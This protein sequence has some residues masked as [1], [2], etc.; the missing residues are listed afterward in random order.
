M[1]KAFFIILFVQSV[2]QGQSRLSADS[3]KA[4]LAVT[5]TDS[6]TLHRYLLF[7]DKLQSDNKESQLLISLWVTEK[8]KQQGFPALS[9]LGH[10]ASARIY[11]E[12]GDYTNA[13]SH[14]GQARLIAHEQGLSIIE[15]K[16]IGLIANIYKSN[17][18]YGKA[19]EYHG[20]AAALSKASNYPT[21][22]GL[23]LYNMGT[24]EYALNPPGKKN[25]EKIIGYL[26]EGY[27]ITA[28]LPENEAAITMASTLARVYSEARKYDSAILYLAK[29]REMIRARGLDE[30]FT[31]YY[32]NL[33]MNYLQ[34]RQFR[35]AYNSFDSGLHY[36]VKYAKPKLEYNYYLALA[37]VCDS[38]GDYK[39]AYLYKN[40]YLYL[41]DSIGS[42]E[43][44][45]IT[46][47][48]ENKYLVALKEKD[49]LA[50]KNEQ[51]IREL[52][53]QREKAINAG[54]ALEAAK[55]ESEIRRL[56]ADEAIRR[57]EL[58]KQAALLESNVL[59]AQQKENQIRL[60]EQQRAA[61]TRESNQLMQL[62]EKDKIASH[63]QLKIQKQTRNFLIGGLFLLS[64]ITLLL[65]R[66][67][68][69]RKK[70]YAALEQK[71]AEIKEQAF[72][73]SRQARLIARFQSQ[74]NPHFTFNALHSIYGLVATH[75]NTKAIQQIQ[76]LAGL[77]RTTLI[78]STEEEISLA[79]EIEYLRKYA[80][81]EKGTTSLAFE[82]DIQVD[83]SLMDA[84]IPPMMIQPFVENSIK[85]G[86]LAKVL[87]PYIKILIRKEDELMKLIIRDNGKGMTGPVLTGEQLSHSMNIIRSRISLLMNKQFPGFGEKIFN[88]QTSPGGTEV[89]FYLPINYPY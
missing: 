24:I 7:S 76:S 1:K 42:S 47:E 4:V 72:E 37:D 43:K 61:E 5:A 27:E 20:E 87:D 44:F 50:L 70:S 51:A 81:F 80:D 35:E 59:E 84:L 17:R 21:G 2:A 60:L 32:Q 79:R 74:M 83:E 23:A 49:I 38:L 58:E 71:N 19:M 53:L 64:I 11:N 28:A 31:T 8:S 14:A 33:G 66:S 48:L 46:A 68:R 65:Y 13:I 22:A 82:F 54:N 77:M 12:T 29:S 36:A 52:E 15:I 30:Y 45:R 69:E 73:L 88:I 40:K 16:S 6:I 62:A 18:Q 56:K 78:N 26:R 67:I 55:K 3:L 86:A 89:S 25:Y 34:L 75:D 63:Q 9:S 39:K 41:H 57:L 10:Y 85:H